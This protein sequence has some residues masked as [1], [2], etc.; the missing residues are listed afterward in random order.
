MM[1]GNTLNML[2]KLGNFDFGAD[3]QVPRNQMRKTAVLVQFVPLPQR[4]VFDPAVQPPAKCA[5]GKAVDSA[6][7]SGL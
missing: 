3:T 7:R 2:F 6:R 4:N 1:T 5:C